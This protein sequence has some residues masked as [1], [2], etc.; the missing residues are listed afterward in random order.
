MYNVII[1][2]HHKDQKYDSGYIGGG[3]TLE[4]AE[5]DLNYHINYYQA[6]C[7]CTIT[8]A[9]ILKVCN[10]CH[11]TGK[12]FIPNKRNKFLGKNKNCPECKGIDSEILVKDYM[13]V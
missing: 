9:K 1:D 3:N 2:Y 10:T 6:E 8:E 5:K 12:I 11:G 7:E 4:L 13:P